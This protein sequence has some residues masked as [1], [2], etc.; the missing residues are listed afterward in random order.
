MV[1]YQTIESLEKNS[2]DAR[3][4]VLIHKMD[5]VAEDSRQK[6]FVERYQLIQSKSPQ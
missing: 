4:F 1:F 3:V 2:P 6:E 5:L